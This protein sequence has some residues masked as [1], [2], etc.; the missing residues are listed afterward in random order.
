MDS[1]VG[2]DQFSQQQKSDQITILYLWQKS[3]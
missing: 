3:F 1:F 2:V